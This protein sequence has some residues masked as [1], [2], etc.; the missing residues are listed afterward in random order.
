MSTDRLAAVQ[1]L[2]TQVQHIQLRCVL[3]R[4]GLSPRLIAV[5]G[6]KSSLPVCLAI[7]GEFSFSHPVFACG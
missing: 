4:S 7:D 2:N 6:C 1:H 3:C 5:P